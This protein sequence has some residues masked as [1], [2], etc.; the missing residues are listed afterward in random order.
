LGCPGNGG[1]KAEHSDCTDP[2]RRAYHHVVYLGV[3]RPDRLLP[4][5][6]VAELIIAQAG[7]PSVTT[8]TITFSRPLPGQALKPVSRARAD[9]ACILPNSDRSWPL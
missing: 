6:Q 9:Y 3:S 7:Y 1:R 4:R 5:W 8:S 2:D